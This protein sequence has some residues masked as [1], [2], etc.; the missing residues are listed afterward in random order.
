MKAWFGTTTPGQVGQN[1]GTVSSREVDYVWRSRKQP[2]VFLLTC[3]N[4]DR[5]RGEPSKE[6][7]DRVRVPDLLVVSYVVSYIYSH[8]VSSNPTVTEGENIQSVKNNRH[9]LVEEWWYSSSGTDQL[10]VVRS[11]R[12]CG[13]VT[14]GQ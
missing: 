4:G 8:D 3:L 9:T 14:S 12:G 10:R 1:R 7:L 6:Y 13:W 5:G 2:N 11:Y